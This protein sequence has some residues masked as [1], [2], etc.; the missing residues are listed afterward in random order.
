M[1][2]ARG[3]T[4]ADGRT[5]VRWTLGPKSKKPELA[6]SVAGSDVS[7]HAGAQRSPMTLMITR[8][9]R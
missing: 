7:K 9:R 5:T 6:G 1:T 8:L 2:P 3:L 4:D